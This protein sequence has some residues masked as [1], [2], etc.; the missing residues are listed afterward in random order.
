MALKDQSVMT[1]VAGF[2]HPIKLPTLADSGRVEMCFY[3]LHMVKLN[4]DAKP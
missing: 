3:M 1:A 2:W 4:C